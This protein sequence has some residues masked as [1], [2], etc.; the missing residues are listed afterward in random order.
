MPLTQLRPGERRRLA[1]PAAGVRIPPRL[2]E[3]GFVP[4]TPVAL[5]RRAP[6]GDPVEVE[7]RG[8]RLCMRVADLALLSV[9][10]DDAP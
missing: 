8:Y 10:A 9:E 3:L 1:P 5:V 6:L 2:E 4:G 7:L